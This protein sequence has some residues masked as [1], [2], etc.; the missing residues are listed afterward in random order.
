M[1]YLAPTGEPPELTDEED[2]LMNRVA[3]L[4]IKRYADAGFAEPEEK[5]Y[6]HLL[7]YAK[8]IWSSAACP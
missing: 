3:S 4:L 8:F 1:T 7:Q 6:A 5:A 2:A